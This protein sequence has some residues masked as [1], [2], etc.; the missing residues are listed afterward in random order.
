MDVPLII[1][2]TTNLGEFNSRDVIQAIKPGT[3]L[4]PLNSLEG[5]ELTEYIASEE[6]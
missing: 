3:G 1:L 5:E 2:E 6:E 4:N